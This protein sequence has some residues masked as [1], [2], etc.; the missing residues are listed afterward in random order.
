MNG[1]IAF[2]ENKNC[3]TVFEVR[4]LIGGLGSVNIE[5]TNTRLGPCPNCGSSGLVPDGVYNYFNQVI[6]FVRGPKDSIEKLLELK[7]LVLGFKYN[8]KS[9]DEIVKEINKISPD[10]AKTIEKAPD[11]DYHKWIATIL[12][13]L[14]AA[15][16][17]HQTY[18]K[19]SDDEIK[20]KV[21]EQ[22]LNQNKALIE[23]AKQKPINVNIKIGRNEKCDCGS[24]LKYKK[25]CLTK[26]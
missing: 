18:F 23:L 7:E 15:I 17:V 4:N 3:G 12:A 13:I 21:I 20:A 9:R 6:S 14:T 26:K 11:V 22:L 25:C 16:L 8:P 1:I 5:L 19:G 24:G 2:C 10:Y